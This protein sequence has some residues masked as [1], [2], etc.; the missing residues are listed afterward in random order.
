MP[1]LKP[2]MRGDQR[3]HEK[4]DEQQWLDEWRRTQEALDKQEQ[5]RRRAWL[6]WLKEQGGR[7]Q[8]TAWMVLPCNLGD[9]GL[10]PLASGTPYW[11]SPFIW[12][13]SPDPSGRPQAGAENHLVARVFNLGAGTAAPAK[14]DFYWAD[15][16]V[17]LG[18][19]DAHFIGTE[20]AEIGPMTSRVVRCAT[21]WI[22][23]YLNNGHEC[24][25]LNCDNHV[26][27][28]LLLPFQPWADRHV[29]QRNLAV[30]PAVAQPFH[31]WAPGGNRAELHVT[32]LRGV[33]REVPKE[34]GNA[35]RL[36]G[37]AA[38][39]LLA[40]LRPQAVTARRAPGGPRQPPVAGQQVPAKTVIAG[41]RQTGAT[42]VLARPDDKL[43][44]MPLDGRAPLGEHLF[45]VDGQAGTAQQIELQLQELTLP[46]NTFVVL[47][48]CHTTAQAVT[49]GYL[50]VL[51][52]PAWFRATPHQPM[53]D[54]SMKI[55]SQD[56]QDAAL[57][58]MVIAQ[59]PQAR[60]TL[61]IARAMQKHLPITSIEEI[62]RAVQY[63]H[64]DDMY[65]NPGMVERFGFKSLLPIR[66]SADLVAKIAGM[67]RIA[68]QQG[69]GGPSS[70]LAGAL[71]GSR[72][73]AIPAA[74]FA[75]PSLF[76]YT[77]AKGE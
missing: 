60:L 51:A 68:A 6:A 59:F 39:H 22:P 40:G 45:K 4:R 66:D 62:E 75:G 12:V 57:Q 19:A 58:A 15:P 10:R 44:P 31:F 67:L 23:S 65:L 43:H 17:G 63:V 38:A 46:L 8:Y 25:F 32:A 52:H 72:G 30:L 29:G 7:A 50:L 41:V 69:H 48:I 13:E 18:A 1:D 73:A 49:G 3:P 74:H 61:Q 76:G 24:A 71:P 16:S 21:P 2:A 35:V 56:P 70:L 54:E 55:P 53:E 77:V 11:A 47:N 27:D 64:V 14:I 9:Y 20:W 42:R 28:P 34:P 26:L 5:A 33:L 37:E 36:L